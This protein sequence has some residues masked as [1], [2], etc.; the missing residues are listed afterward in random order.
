[1]TATL[2]AFLDRQ[3]ELIE[4][5]DLDGL[6]ERYHEDAVLV[7]PD[8]VVRGRPALRALF[9]TYLA[10]P[11]RVVS[12][13]SF[14]AADNSLHYQATLEAG[15]GAG[16]GTRRDY[17]AFVLREGKIWRQFAGTL[18]APAPRP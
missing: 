9:A 15:T 5:G 17:G 12:V 13:D 10:P 3:I 18:A 8:A 7:R 1:M 4:A 14:A 11:P 6:L 2:R 16:A